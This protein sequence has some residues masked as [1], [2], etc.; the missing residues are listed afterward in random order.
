MW[1]Y[2]NRQWRKIMATQTI[3]DRCGKQCV[4]DRHGR[5]QTIST[6]IKA[7]GWAMFPEDEK[8]TW[9]ICNDCFDG[10]IKWL[11]EKEF[12]GNDHG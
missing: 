6:V 8:A 12:G 11:N 1:R 10:F 5:I 9:D 3:C 2:Q 7:W 4:P